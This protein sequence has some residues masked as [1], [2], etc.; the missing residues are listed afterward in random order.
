MLSPNDVPI[1]L[2]CDI[3][4]DDGDG[5]G[6]EGV[7]EKRR[8]EGSG[9]VGRVLKKKNHCGS[10]NEIPTTIS[11]PSSKEMKRRGNTSSCH[12]LVYYMKD[13]SMAMDG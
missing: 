1:G 2:L 11:S 5:A 10:G 9:L 3:Y 12:L 13:L 4:T 8:K 6:R 7:S